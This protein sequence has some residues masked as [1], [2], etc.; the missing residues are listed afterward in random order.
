MFYCNKGLFTSLNNQ[1]LQSLQ[2][3]EF[4][5]DFTITRELTNYILRNDEITVLFIYSSGLCLVGRVRHLGLSSLAVGCPRVIP[6]ILET[7]SCD[8]LWIVKVS[9]PTRPNMLNIINK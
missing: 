4:E 7:G 6:F 3:D 9:F 2:I 5:K 1:R 8:N